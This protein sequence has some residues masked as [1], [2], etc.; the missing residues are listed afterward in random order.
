MK[1]EIKAFLNKI[2]F[3]GDSYICPVCNFHAK[4]FLD[5]GLYTKRKQA[6]CPNCGSLERHRQLYLI[7]QD[8]LNLTEKKSLLHFAP[9]RCLKQVLMKKHHLNYQTSYY[10]GQQQGDFC[11]DIQNIDAKDNSFNYIIC[12]HVLEHVD[13]DKKAISEMYRILYAGGIAF[14]QVPVWPSEKHPTYENSNII[15][16]HDRIIHFG[17]FDHVRIYGLDIEQRLT[18]SGFDEVLVLD[19]SQ[20]L[21]ELKIQ[22]YGLKNYGGARDLTFVCK[23]FEN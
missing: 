10:E 5:S 20:T 23:K 17:Q 14:I 18:E 1:S 19:L 16:E 8:Y 15:D 9:E 3:A 2:K 22:K 13:N 4:K 7:L 21:E 6:K 12:S 11:Y